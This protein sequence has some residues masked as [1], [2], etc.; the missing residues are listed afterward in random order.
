MSNRTKI[1]LGVLGIFVFAMAAAVFDFP[2]ALGMRLPAAWQRPFRL[3]LD[4]QG[5]V[6]LV[7]SADVDNV[8]EADQGDALEG[9]RDVIERRVNIFGVSEPVVQTAKSGNEWRVIVELPG[10]T[11]VNA[12]VNLIAETP[13]LEFKIINP[14]PTTTA[15]VI[16]E[17]EVK[18][19][20]EAVLKQAL[21]P[22]A[23][24][25]ALAKEHSDDSSGD[26]GGELGWA[27]RGMFVPEFEAACFDQGQVGRVHPELVQTRFGFHVIQ[28]LE[29]RGSGDGL[30]ARCRHILFSTAAPSP[31]DEWMNTGLNGAHL[32]RATVAFDP[33]TS[34]PQVS[35]QFNPEGADLFSQITQ[36]SIG[37]PVGIFLDGSLI[38]S[39]VVREAITTG[40][41]V[42]SGNFTVAEAKQLRE[43]L[44][45]GALPVPITII[46][47]QTIGPTLGQ[48]AVQKSLYAGVLGVLLI[49]GYLLVM[50][51]WPGVLASLTL[52]VYGLTVL[53][54]FK[55]IPV[56]LTLAGISGFIFSLGIAVD[57]NILV[58]E[59]LKEELRAGNLLERAIALSYRRA[60]PSIRDSNLST[61]LTC[62]VLLGFSTS[63]VKGFAL[64]LALGIL[65]NLVT[66]MVASRLLLSVFQP[67]RRAERWLWWYGVRTSTLA[68][69]RGA[70]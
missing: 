43:R 52:V 44:N 70:P 13:R 10:V 58:F 62:L 46:S 17:A 38:S 56:T 27:K 40:S 7:Y 63:I 65:V 66:T 1:R 39:P 67:R 32:K 61:L 34:E 6:Q 35:L 37:Q 64:T 59:R 22:G 24:F 19:Q 15:P 5:G 50:Y 41:A 60:W 54:L 68:R 26:A 12:A 36:R 21:G 47:Q 9:A 57:A 16:N 55:L 3:G 51:R 31:A 29:R 8:P 2:D 49:V 23:D 25:T 42:I 11:D 20:A 4:L 69:P 30:E 45:A 18:A 48:A 14:N 28:P 53:T 33:T